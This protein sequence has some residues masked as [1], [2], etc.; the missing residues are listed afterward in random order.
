M[1]SYLYLN[2]E[3]SIDV[4]IDRASHFP[5][6]AISHKEIFEALGNGSMWIKN[7]VINSQAR[8]GYIINE[9]HN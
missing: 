8:R 6:K 7:T 5:E 3:K 4:L 9:E 2:F 1:Y